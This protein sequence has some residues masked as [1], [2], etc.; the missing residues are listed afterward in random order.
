MSKMSVALL[1]LGVVVGGWSWY[2]SGQ[3]LR[4]ILVDEDPGERWIYD[5]FDAAAARAKAEKKPIFALF[6]CVP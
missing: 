4:E 2:R 1:A 6:R 5:D 3:P